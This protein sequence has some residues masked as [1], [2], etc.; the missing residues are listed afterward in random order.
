MQKLEGSAERAVLGH[1]HDFRGYV[2][3]LER[4]KFL[5]GRKSKVAQ[6]T[7]RSVT[8]RKP[9]VRGDNEGLIEFYY[10]ISD[11]LITLRM[12]NY[13]ADLYS[14]ETLE[15]ATGRLSEDLLRK[16][17]ERSVSIRVKGVEPNLF[18]LEEWLQTRV[19]VIQEID[20]PS[21]TR[22]HERKINH[23][24]MGTCPSCGEKHPVWKCKD[25]LNHVPDGR[26]DMARSLKLCYNCLSYGHVRSQC[27]SKGKCFQS[28]CDERHHT[29]LHEHYVKSDSSA[30]AADSSIVPPVV[31]TTVGRYST[32][33]RRV[34]LQVVPVKLQ[35]GDRSC[36]T[37]ALLDNGSESTLLRD[38]LSHK[39]G[40]KGDLIDVA[41][42]TFKDDPEFMQF[43][44]V[45][46]DI[47]S[48]D[49][50][51]R[52]QVKGGLVVPAERFHMPDRPRLAECS[53]NDFFTHLDGI[54]LDAVTS[55]DIGILIGGDVPEALLTDD[56]RYGRRDQPLAVHT[57]F[58]WTLFG[59]ATK[60]SQLSVNSLSVQRVPPPGA[61]A[62]LVKFWSEGRV[63]RININRL[64]I[65]TSDRKEQVREDDE[66]LDA[67]E[68][69]WKV[70]QEPISDRETAMSRED[71]A[72]LETLDR[73]TTLEGGRYR[74]PMLWKDPSA[75]L[76]NNLPYAMKRYKHTRKRLRADPDLYAKC[77]AVIEGHVRKGY[78][79]KLSVEE[80]RNTGPRTWTLPTFPVTNINKPGKVRLVNDAAA[81]YGGTSLNDALLTGPDLLNSM[82]GVLLRFRVGKIAFCAD[83]EEMF[84][85]ILVSEE[86]SDSLR[87]LWQDDVYSDCPPDTYKMLVHIFGAKDS[88]TVANYILRRTSRDHAQDF[89]ASTF[90]TALRSFYVDDS[91]K[92]VESVAAAISLAKQLREMMGR[93]GF[94]LT[95]FISNSKAVLD[96]LPPS[97]SF[98]VS[99]IRHR[100]R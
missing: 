55:S 100:R 47:L 24:Q 20:R 85:R 37:F 13:V 4:L 6:A 8:H 14:T 7:I 45:D 64:S 63:P 75:T 76:P 92:S 70:E 36:S 39:L 66:L 77:K 48:H 80:A 53:D 43:R 84:L 10:S 17:G 35:A 58:G 86:D 34:F 31:V 89:D 62:L 9:L 19:L 87:F 32:E 41:V 18:H 21:E 50:K 23:V 33:N 69:F 40:L 54:H 79:R 73:E 49:G 46:F 56:V 16:W 44:D 12:L 82:I 72:A 96:A 27:P 42:G 68:K 1:T 3:S 28:N 2:L 71:V 97:V 90:E 30:P 51:N 74:A 15:R 78:A 98:S 88:A 94:R 95:K 5:F 26:F 93:G 81:R 60:S 61:D 91:L 67:L 38:D 25:Y 83:V 22:P 59:G 11:C 57:K 52:F 99:F 65:T 29:T